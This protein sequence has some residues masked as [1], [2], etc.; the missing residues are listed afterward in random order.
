MQ[1]PRKSAENTL[2]KRNV[3]PAAEATTVDFNQPDSLVGRALDG[4]FM[5]EKNLT[6][7]GAD[8]GGIGV[9]YLARDT[10]LMGKEVVVKIL[11]ETALKHPDIVR[12]FE[13]EKE[14][15]IRLDHPGIVRILDSGRL[16]DGNPF[17]V[18]DYIKGHSLRKA[19]QMAGKLPLEV[20]ASIIES[21]TDALSA[22]H[23]EKI[24]HRD[25]KPENIMLT[26]IDEGMYRVRLIDFGIARVEDSKLAPAT[27]IS[28]A[29][30][31]ILYISPEQLIGKLDLT[32]AADIYSFAIVAYEMLTGELPFKPKA[33]AE[34]YQLEKE[35]VKTPP[36]VLRPDMPR[37]AEGILLSALEFDPEKR[38]QM[39]RAFGRYLA[40][41]LRIDGKE[42]DRFFASVQTDYSKLPTQFVESP[43]L[44]VESLDLTEART[45]E[46]I[47]SNQNREI[48]KWVKWG[49]PAVAVFFIVSFGLAY[50]ALNLAIPSEA[51]SQRAGNILPAALETNREFSYY[52]S[53]Q[54]MRDGVKFEEPFR[55]SGQEIFES[56]YKFTINLRTE[57]DGYMYIL[58]EGKDD[59][60]NVGFYVLFPSPSTNDGS[61]MVRSGEEVE[62]AQ[63]TFGGGRGT[64][65]L[66]VF[67]TKER[68]ENLEPALTT[69]LGANGAV[70]E[71]SRGRLQEFIAKHR[72][73]SRDV[74]KDSAEQRTVVR[75]SG[76]TI[77]HRFE[78]EHR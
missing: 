9:V 73:E 10:K 3:S 33:I 26:P 45:V 30:G 70:S 71:N 47:Q 53:V 14:A 59:Q 55:S 60:G 57:E 20:V 65:I 58:N 12:K 21:V 27:E 51:D 19:L 39:A 32:P 1:A 29:I 8:T 18:M 77:I 48:S 41:E 74:A 76:D 67:W 37:V 50:L 62:T 5:I 38:P 49:I 43:D 13:H 54:K 68:Q 31:S 72:N 78:L 23:S 36:S 42:T 22:A 28:R 11:N 52:L 15:L 56:G 44:T 40:N 17:M 75:G 24:L 16:V 61:A 34:M 46:R 63:N 7:T 25:I 6:D 69:E 66:W 35:G 64:E 2:G 4:R